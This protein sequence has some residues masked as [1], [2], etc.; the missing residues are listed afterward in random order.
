MTFSR[1]LAKIAARGRSAF[2]KPEQP[3]VGQAGAHAPDSSLAL[4]G[5]AH[6]QAT[7]ARSRV[8][9]ALIGFCALYA[10]IGVR[11]VQLGFETPSGLNEG[12]KPSIGTLASRPDLLD[13]R[14]RILA[15]DIR[16]SSLL[17][18]PRRVVDADEAIEKL[19]TVL[20]SIDVPTFHKRLTKDSGFEWLARELTPREQSRILE[21]GIPGIGF[22]PETRRFYPD[23]QLASHIVGHVNTVQT[24]C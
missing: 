24:V 11:L 19:S 13:R 15:T 14:G 4:Q 9:I 23:G 17:V 18:E 7:Q 1:H 3:V 2:L 10:L 5:E 21:L 12:H 6:V 20:P 16:T 8:V 22:R